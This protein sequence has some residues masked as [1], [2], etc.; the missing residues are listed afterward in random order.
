[1]GRLS[2]LRCLMCQI[3]L[4]SHVTRVW[5]RPKRAKKN[6]HVLWSSCLDVSVNQQVFVSSKR[7]HI[8]ISHS[9]HSCVLHLLQTKVQGV[10]A[11]CTVPSSA[12]NPSSSRQPSSAADPSSSGQ[13]SSPASHLLFNKFIIVGGGFLVLL[14]NLLG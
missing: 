1:M 10:S 8:H 14:T 3:V 7:R 13:P 9:F 11:E 6:W 2:T 4:A 12:A 5:L